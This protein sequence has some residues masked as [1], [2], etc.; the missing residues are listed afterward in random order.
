MFLPRRMQ[1]A[2]V[3]N[4]KSTSNYLTNAQMNAAKD[5]EKIDKVNWRQKKFS[6]TWKRVFKRTS[7]GETQKEKKRCFNGSSLEQIQTMYVRCYAFTVH[8]MFDL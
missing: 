4:H 7:T 8:F 5:F 2:A 6:A 1:C 3:G